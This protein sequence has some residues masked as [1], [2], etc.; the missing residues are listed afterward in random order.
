ME[1]LYIFLAV[2]GFSPQFCLIKLYQSRVM[3]KS[4]KTPV[5]AKKTA[6]FTMASNTCT[7]VLFFF[8][9]GFKV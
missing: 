7:F 9:N 3:D 1:Y 8:I 6:F 4:M 5:I 2:I